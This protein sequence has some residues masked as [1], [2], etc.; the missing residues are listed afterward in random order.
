MFVAYHNVSVEARSVS[1]AG[2]YSVT[3]L[4]FYVHNLHIVFPVVV[5]CA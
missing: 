1:T 3:D 4:G 5:K 2:V